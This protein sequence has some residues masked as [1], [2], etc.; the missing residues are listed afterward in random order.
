MK[1]SEEIF[2]FNGE[3]MVSLPERPMRQGLF[4]KTLEDALQTLLERY[5]EII[6]GKQIV[7]DTE[8]PPRFFLLRRE[9]PI[10]GWSLD[11]LFVDQHGVLTLVEAKLIENPESR[12]DVIGQIIEY[13]ANAVKLWADGKVR[14]TVSEYFAGRGKNLDSELQ[15]FL[16]DEGDIDTF[17]RQVESNLGD[18]NI[19]LIIASD[20]IR[21]EVR[22]MIEY[23][24][25]EM[26]RATVLGLELKCF[27]DDDASIVM[28]PRIIGQTQAAID[29]RT[30]QEKPTLWT[31]DRI[32]VALDEIPAGILKTRMMSV[33]EWADKNGS[34]AEKKGKNMSI[35]IKNSE[36]RVF[37]TLG[38]D[39]GGYAGLAKGYHGDQEEKARGFIR[40]L[41]KIGLLA[42]D[43]DFEEISDGRQLITKIGDLD[44]EHFDSLLKELEFYI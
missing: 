32:K 31:K 15:V 29:R 12:R 30:P 41:S 37:L 38:A 17:W 36:G 43:S 27:G 7:A 20:E 34:L 24:N 40:S 3:N 1:K 8:D 42:T 28:V 14:Q 11:H 13:A 10:S 23:L 21:P 4:D 26:H 22:R 2:H 44:Q 39:G 25:I 35:R 19:R 5:P 9:M 18:G 33:L 16:G 6:P